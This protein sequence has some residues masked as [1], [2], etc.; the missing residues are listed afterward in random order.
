[1]AHHVHGER[2]NIDVAG[3][4]AVAEERALDPVSARQN[5]QLGCGN[6]GP[7]VV[8]RMQGEDHILALGEI[9]VHPFDAIRVDIWGSD[10]DRRRQVDDGLVFRRR[11]PDIHHRLADL[12]GIGQFGLGV[13]LGRVLMDDLGVGH[14]RHQFL[15]QLRPVGRDLPD[16]VHI[17]VEYDPAL[18]RRCRVVEMDDRRMG[19]VDR[20]EGAADQLVPGLREDLYH[21]VVGDQVLVDDLAAEVEVR[22]GGGRESDLDLLEAHIAERLEHLELPLRTHGLDQ[23]LVAVTQVDGAPGRA[24]GD[25]LVRPGSVVPKPTVAAGLYFSLA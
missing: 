18:G 1:M 21:H 7:A 24:L 12:H 2:D 16:P 8:V 25:R 10:F 17:E 20:L 11:L 19:A 3:A 4:L 9:A 5:S 22:L 13:A 23:G 15:D 6:S 14:R